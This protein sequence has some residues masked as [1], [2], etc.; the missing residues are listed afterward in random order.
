VVV[1]VPDHVLDLSV[2]DLPTVLH[3]G[4]NGVPTDKAVATVSTGVLIS[5]VALL[6]ASPVAG[7][8]SD[9][10]GRRKLLVAGS[11]FVF[12]IG[13]L[14]LL[15]AKDVSHFYAVEAVLG[16][17]YGIYVGVD[18]ALVVDV[19]PNPDDSGK[20]LGVFNMANAMPQTLAPALGGVLLAIASATH[21]NYD[22]LLWVAGIACIVGALVVL[23]IKKVR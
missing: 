17:S 11:T 8:I 20:N 22:L 18:L 5:T 21:K 19:L 15:V 7:W 16:V 10:T 13:I 14:M 6:V 12:A 3:A 4:P 9:R 1:P 23:P 2:H